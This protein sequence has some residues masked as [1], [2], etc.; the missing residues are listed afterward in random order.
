LPITTVEVIEGGQKG[1]RVALATKLAVDKF[2]SLGV[3]KIQN[4]CNNVARRYSALWNA[5]SSEL[6]SEYHFQITYTQGRSEIQPDFVLF[7]PSTIRINVFNSCCPSNPS[8]AAT[9]VHS[10]DN[11]MNPTITIYLDALEISDSAI[12]WI[13]FSASF[14]SIIYHELLH[15]CGDSPVLRNEVH[16]GVIRHTLVCS[17][18]INNLCS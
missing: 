13:G 4:E 16:D 14:E 17:E 7:E 3:T 9:V 5:K 8:I 2:F 1:Q 6:M 10:R 12:N 18:A 11:P 15:A